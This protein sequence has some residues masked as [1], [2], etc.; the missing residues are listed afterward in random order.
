MICIPNRTH[1]LTKSMVEDRMV[2]VRAMSFFA[3]VYFGIVWVMSPKRVVKR[4]AAAIE[5]ID[6]THKKLALVSGNQ[7]NLTSTIQTLAEAG[8]LKDDVLARG[9]TT[10]ASSTKW[11]LNCAIAKTT[12]TLTPYGRVVQNMKLPGLNWHFVHPLAML[13]QLASLSSQFFE[14][15]KSCIT[16]GMPLRI[17]I[18]IDEICPGNPLRPE[19]SRTLQ[20][21]YWAFLEWPQWLLQ[22]TGAWFVFGTIRSSFVE[23][24]PGGVAYLMTRILDVFFGGEQSFSI[25]V[26]LSRDGDNIYMTGAF[27]GFLADEKALNQI[28]DSKGA[29]GLHQI[30]YFSFSDKTQNYKSNCD[31]NNVQKSIIRNLTIDMRLREH[32]HG[33]SEN[34]IRH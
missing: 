19:K 32:E 33:G 16:P 14:L 3:Y 23:K 29:A 13:Y 30:T 11:Q 1:M 10:K 18:Y 26:S 6:I 25:G 28:G 5:D 21:I 20:A 4:P 22:R 17:I 9:C 34:E 31:N 2:Q 7:T 8:W 24:L 12:K 15:M 27:H